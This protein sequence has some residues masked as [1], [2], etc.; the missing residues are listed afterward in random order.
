MFLCPCII[1]KVVLYSEFAVSVCIHVMAY[2][3]IQGINK[4]LDK[5][6][7]LT[8]FRFRGFQLGNHIIHLVYLFIIQGQRT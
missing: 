3:N 4:K 8:I 2:S 1:S 6:A 7:M 5:H